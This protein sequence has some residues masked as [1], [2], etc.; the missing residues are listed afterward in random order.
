MVMLAQTDTDAE[1]EHGYP[2]LSP[3]LADLFD[4]GTGGFTAAMVEA[5][6]YLREHPYA[7]CTLATADREQTIVKLRIAGEGWLS[8]PNG[9][10]QSRRARSVAQANDLR[11]S[12]LRFLLQV[13]KAQP[14][15]AIAAS[16]RSD[17]EQVRRAMKNSAWFD[18][19]GKG[20]TTAYTASAMGREQQQAKGA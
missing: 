6:R 5:D 8:F 16:V 2:L 4:L 14:L 13:G 7:V 19:R 1:E 12:I 17:T 10:A 20:N 3:A 15:K 18:R 9:A 11:A